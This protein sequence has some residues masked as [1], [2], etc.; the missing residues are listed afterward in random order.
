M[1]FERFVTA[2]VP[3]WEKENFPAK[4]FTEARS[5]SPAK[6]LFPGDHKWR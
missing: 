4:F 6:Y 3:E 1:S 5:G 2:F